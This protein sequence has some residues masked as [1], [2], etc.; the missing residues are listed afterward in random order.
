VLVNDIPRAPIECDL[1]QI[2]SGHVIGARRG[3]NP[4]QICHAW[5][6]TPAYAVN[7]DLVS[8]GEGPCIA[9]P[10]LDPL[11]Y[12]SYKQEIAWTGSSCG[13]TCLLMF[14]WYEMEDHYLGFTI[15]NTGSLDKIC[16][17]HVDT[18]YDFSASTCGDFTHRF[19]GAPA[20]CDLTSTGEGRIA[21]TVDANLY[22]GGGVKCH[23][24]HVTP[25]YKVQGTF[26]ETGPGQCVA[27]PT[28]DINA[29][30]NYL[31]YVGE[32]EQWSYSTC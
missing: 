1:T 15:D 8:H 23:G 31:K 4:D 11:R 10:T 14:R 12:I 22:S 2:G 7:A 9:A 21:G 28:Q 27:G 13:E 24:Y 17:C 32:V 6:K 25:A 20:S 16:K 29:S 26:K 30:Y 19:L 18:L 3:E 5:Q